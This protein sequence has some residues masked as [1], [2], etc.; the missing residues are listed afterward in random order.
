MK[1]P[2]RNLLAVVAM[3]LPLCSLSSEVSVPHLGLLSP[4]VPVGDPI[5]EAQVLT[6]AKKTFPNL[7]SD[8]SNAE[9]LRRAVEDPSMRGNLRGRLAEE[10]FEKLHGREGWTRVDNPFAQQNDFKRLINGR[11][12]GAQIKVHADTHDYIRS[13]MVKDTLAERFVVPDDHYDILKREYAVRREAALRGGNIV[14]AEEYARQSDRLMKL[15]HTFR[16]LD[17]AIATSAKHYRAIAAAVW[18]AGKGVSFIAIAL[19]VVEGTIA[20]YEFASGKTDVVAYATKLGKVGIGGVASWIVAMKALE[21]ATTAGATGLAPVA[22]AI[23]VGTATYL[24]VDW[25]FDQTVKSLSVAEISDREVNLV[26]PPGV[27]RIPLNM[28]KPKI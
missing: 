24:V 28:S 27:P 11:W 17:G 6:L 21:L 14:K 2:I 26:W 4:T 23:V 18:R 19:G 1:R 22:V 9:V 20:T 5:R 13:M 15:G 10:I 25:A 16:E 8:L 3:A 7:A 12:E